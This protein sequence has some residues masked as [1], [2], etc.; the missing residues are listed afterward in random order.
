MTFEPW[1]DVMNHITRDILY[2]DADCKEVM[3]KLISTTNYLLRTKMM[4]MLEMMLRIM[5]KGM[6]TP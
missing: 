6:R 1:R 5:T 4:M 2:Q 3:K